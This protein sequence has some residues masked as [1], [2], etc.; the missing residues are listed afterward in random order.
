VQSNKVVD[1]LAAVA[2]VPSD[3]VNTAAQDD[4]M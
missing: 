4:S 2:S 1:E 3:A